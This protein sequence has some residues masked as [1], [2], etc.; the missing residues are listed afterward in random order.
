M[1][2][3]A[4]AA[5]AGQ[6]RFVLLEVVPE[7]VGLAGT[8]ARVVHALHVPRGIQGWPLPAGPLWVAGSS[9]IVQKAF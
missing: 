5:T 8:A 2:Q 6:L 7:A 3:F 9:P 4:G 1:L